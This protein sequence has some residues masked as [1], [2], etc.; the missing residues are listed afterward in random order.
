MKQEELSAK[1]T[2]KYLPFNRY[3]YVMYMVLVIY[4]AVKGDYESAF[5]NLGIALIFDPFDPSV[6]WQ[7][8]PM[9]QRVWLLI[10]VTVMFAGLLYIFFLKH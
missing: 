2:P 3:A 10:H 7:Q 9:Y 6:K 8:R 1:T 5:T 4:I